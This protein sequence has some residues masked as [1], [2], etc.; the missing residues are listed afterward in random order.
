VIKADFI[1][2]LESGCAMLVA[3]VDPSGMPRATRGWG[4][5]VL[6]PSAGH[7][8]I[9]LADDDPVTRDN[10]GSTARLAV[11]GTDIVTLRSVQGKGRALSVEMATASDRHRAV[12]FCDAFFDNIQRIDATPLVLL[13]R[14]VPRAYYS[15]VAVIDEWFDQTPGP[16]AGVPVDP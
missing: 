15:C 9:V 5:R 14:L 6:D 13:Q 7:V 16:K 10:L 1:A 11:T 2:L 12:R 3:T 8:R 4:L